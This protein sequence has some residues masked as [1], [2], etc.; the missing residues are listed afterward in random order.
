MLFGSQNEP[1]NEFIRLTG[2]GK[3]EVSLP[4]GGMG[5]RLSRSLWF[6][7]PGL[8]A[9]NYTVVVQMPDFLFAG[10]FSTPALSLIHI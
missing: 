1:N 7:D 2:N 9:W 6:S 10:V 3:G 4:R 8:V 5:G